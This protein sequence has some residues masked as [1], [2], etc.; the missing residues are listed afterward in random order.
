MRLLWFLRKNTTKQTKRKPTPVVSSWDT[1][2]TGTG[3]QKALCTKHSR[4]AMAT[5]QEMKSIMKSLTNRL[6]SDCFPSL[7]L[8]ASVSTSALML[9]WYES[10]QNFVRDV[11]PLLEPF[12]HWAINVRKSGYCNCQDALLRR[13]AL[14]LSSPTL[15]QAENKNRRL[16][17]HLWKIFHGW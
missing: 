13:D 2:N 7:P 17:L 12:M 4:R 1:Q 10:P 16:N 9:L 11:F 5:S 8:T 14:W 6:I 15:S 3:K